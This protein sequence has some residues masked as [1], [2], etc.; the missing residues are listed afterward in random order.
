MIIDERL[1]YSKSLDIPKNIRL[2]NY[3][4]VTIIK[5][6]DSIGIQSVGTSSM[7]FSVVEEGVDEVGLSEKTIIYILIM[8]GFFFL[9]FLGLFIYSLFFRDK[10]LKEMDREY[11]TELGKQRKMIEGQGKQD[12][13]KLET[14]AEKKEYKKEL[15]EIKKQRFNALKQ[16]KKKKFTEFKSIKKK[17]KGNQRK[18]QLQVWK[19]KGYDTS[20]LEKKYKM[21][22]INNIKAKV[23]AWKRKGYDTSVLEKR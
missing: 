12:Y 20:I 11:R 7:Y 3:V 4:L 2:G 23:R 18:Q 22:N 21:P 1:D 5:Y 10:M 19:R 17:Y 14:S 6:T 8:F 16:V 13:S 15:E 9:I